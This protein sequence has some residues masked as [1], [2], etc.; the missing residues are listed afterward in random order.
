M[1]ILAGITVVTMLVGI[2]FLLWWWRLADQWVD[3]EQRRFGPRADVADGATRVVVR[4]R[5]AL[6][7][8]AM[9]EPAMSE[10]VLSEPARNPLG[11]GEPKTTQARPSDPE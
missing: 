9:S 10:P 8:P 4:T 6:S 11:L 1:W 5:P 2:P 3:A 7:E